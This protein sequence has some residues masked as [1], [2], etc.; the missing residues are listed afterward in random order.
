MLCNFDFCEFYNVVLGGLLIGIV[1]S[2]VFIWL[3]NLLKQFNFRRQ[4]NH[5]ES[6]SDKFDWIAYSMKKEE[7][8]VR[9]DQPNGSKVNLKIKKDKIYIRLQHGNREWKGEII[10]HQNHF[11]VV[12]Y[13]YI[14][15]HEYGRRECII[16][17]F[18][19]NGHKFNYIFLVP[20]DN[21]LYYIET[22][23]DGKLRPLYNYGE[24][25]LVREKISS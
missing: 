20:L 8:R 9:E 24:E 1:T 25:I 3:T 23:H 6:V 7:G 16:G 10:M 17:E 12:T 18:E 13:R 21:K 5:L 4:Y 22:Q 19:E 2:F 15:K 14:D 11:G